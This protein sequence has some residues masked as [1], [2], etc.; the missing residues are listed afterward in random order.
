MTDTDDDLDLDMPA[1]PSRKRRVLLVVAVVLAGAGFLAFKS[2]QYRSRQ[3]VEANIVNLKSQLQSAGFTLM[4]ESENITANPFTKSAG[5]T[6]VSVFRNATRLGIDE[7]ALS[8]IQRDPAGGL[9]VIGLVEAKGVSLQYAVQYRG[10]DGAPQTN[11]QNFRF[12]SVTVNDL[13]STQIQ[14][15]FYSFIAGKIPPTT[16]PYASRIEAQRINFNGPEFTGT[17]DAMTIDQMQHSAEAFGG[18]IDLTGLKMPVK[19]NFASGRVAEVMAAASRDTLDMPKLVIDYRFEPQKTAFDLSID[20]TVEGLAAFKGKVRMNQVYVSFLPPPDSAGRTEVWPPVL[21]ETLE[22][23]IE[24]KG[25]TLAFLKSQAKR[26]QQD[27]QRFREST[28]LYLQQVSSLGGPTAESAASVYKHI[29]N[30]GTIHLT[31]MPPQLPPLNDRDW[32]VVF[33]NAGGGPGAEDLG[34]QFRAQ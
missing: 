8:D 23:T 15:L 19:T 21:L 12:A 4:Y 17:A 1:K 7:L 14:N 34:I 20:S 31:A 25:M 22:A 2:M 5:I 28:K 16:A 26:F 30:P 9:G 33:L 11:N 18:H 29:E 13:D 32:V 3:T 6:S 24:D 27:E 10:P